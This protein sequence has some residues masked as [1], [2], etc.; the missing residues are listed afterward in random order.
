MHS[1]TYLR[2]PAIGV[3]QR[4]IASARMTSR[5]LSSLGMKEHENGFV[6]L[7]RRN[8]NLRKALEKISDDYLTREPVNV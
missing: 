1:L 8:I 7:K 4:A 3:N 6:S 2:Y 5:A